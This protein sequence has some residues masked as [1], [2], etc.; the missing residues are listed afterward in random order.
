[1]ASNCTQEGVPE[2]FWSRT[3]RFPALL[4]VLLFTSSSS[5]GNSSKYS[6]DRA[7]A[8]E[9][10]CCGCTSGQC[11]AEPPGSRCVWES[12]I[13][14]HGESPQEGEQKPGRGLGVPGWVCRH[15]PVIPG[16]RWWKEAG[17]LQ[18][19]GQHGR[20]RKNTKAERNVTPKMKTIEAS[21]H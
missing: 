9:H 19:P 12:E 11:R 5:R 18:S 21:V 8:K 20:R 6:D 2:L 14:C 16:V 10:L 1:M 3:T 17:R 15:M 13:S 4:P 7:G